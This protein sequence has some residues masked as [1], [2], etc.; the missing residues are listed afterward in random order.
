MRSRIS[1]RGCVHRS[2]GW[3]VGWSVRRPQ[4][5]WNH[6]LRVWNVIVRQSKWYL[7]S[8]GTKL[9]VSLPLKKWEQ[10]QSHKHPIKNRSFPWYPFTAQS[11]QANHS[12]LA[13]CHNFVMIFSIYFQTNWATG[14][15]TYV[16]WFTLSSL[17][18][19]FWYEPVA[20]SS[21]CTIFTFSHIPTKEEASSKC[22]HF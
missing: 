2:I 19:Y 16:I 5:S 7:S 11:I 12:F 17:Q 21:H 14:M 4:M 1:I 10:I 20:K 22:C 18:K 8:N 3:L 15:N 9:Q 13:S 6:E